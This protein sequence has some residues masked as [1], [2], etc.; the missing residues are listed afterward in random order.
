MENGAGA[1]T[2]IG[3]VEG[4]LIVD[5]DNVTLVVPRPTA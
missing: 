1:V 5:C 3:A 4:E 2:A